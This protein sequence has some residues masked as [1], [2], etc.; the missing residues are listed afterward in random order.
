MQR[1]PPEGSTGNKNSLPLVKGIVLTKQTNDKR[2]KKDK[3][4]KKKAWG[5]WNQT[6]LGFESWLYHLLAGCFLV[7]S[8]TSP[9]L[10]VLIC[11]IGII[12]IMSSRENWVRNA[13]RGT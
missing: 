3:K 13:L 1:I 11:E 2:K 5:P 8:F 10:S 9:N 4:E 6:D 7:D 12:I